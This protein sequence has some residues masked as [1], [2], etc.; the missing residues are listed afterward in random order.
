MDRV[1]PVVSLAEVWRF[2]SVRRHQ[3]HLLTRLSGGRGVA[4]AVHGG[5][6]GPADVLV[7]HYNMKMS[8]RV[9]IWT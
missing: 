6:L 2:V 8:S 7:R 5:A 1:Y 4:D 3:E 9:K